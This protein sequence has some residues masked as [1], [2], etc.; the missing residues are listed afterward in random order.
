VTQDKAAMEQERRISIVP[1]T[2]EL[3]PCV[4]G[5]SKAYW[6]RPTS[7]AFFDWRYL[8]PAAITRMFIA[9][10]GEECVGMLSALRK[11]YRLHGEV[12]P[13]LE[14]FDWHAL[15]EV[16]STG[17]GIRLMRAMM[18][19]PE[20][21]VAVGGTSDVHAAL[22]LLGWQDIGVAQ[23][24]ELLVGI[25]LIAERLER[26]RKVPQ[27]LTRA[28][29]APVPRTVFGP[30]RAAPPAGG[31]MR[32]AERPGDAVSALYAE[33][34]GRDLVQQPDQQVLDWMLASRWSGKCQCLH[35]LIDG[36]LRG[37]AMTR[38]HVGNHGLQGTILDMFA[39][40]PALYRWMVSEAAVSLLAAR[41]RSIVA[42]ASDPA[43]QRAL[44]A[45]GFRHA[46]VDAPARTWPKFGAELPRN[47]H[48]SF[49]HSDAPLIPYRTE[50]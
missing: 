20:R 15:A 26:T 6:K 41:P 42:R 44:A 16:R 48:F 5:F 35:F 19:Q 30:R 8:Q 24:Y 50:T 47:P 7:E 37:W 25:D 33:P 3:L 34:T 29:L 2:P 12:V 22:P 18:R 17:V 21:I 40:E 46:G 11:V 27:G 4:I 9:L 1:F 10:R 38:V 28:L 32:L 45:T 39:P 36:R 14:T 23:A 31:E 43:L 13:C 49:M